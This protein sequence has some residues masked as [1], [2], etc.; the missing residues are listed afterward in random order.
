MKSRS[1]KLCQARENACDQVTLVLVLHLIGWVGGARFLNQ[2][3]GVAKQ[4]QINSGLLSTLNWKLL[5]SKVRD[6]YHMDHYFVIPNTSGH[7]ARDLHMSHEAKKVKL[8]L[9]TY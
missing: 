3:Q 7:S 6:V 4:N 9:L 5:K 2:S 8:F 1:S